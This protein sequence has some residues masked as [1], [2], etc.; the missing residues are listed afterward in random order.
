VV[1]S[2]PGRSDRTPQVT[3]VR[4]QGTSKIAVLRGKR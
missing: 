2:G 3:S 1:G 4:L